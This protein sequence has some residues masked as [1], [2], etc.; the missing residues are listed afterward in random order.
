MSAAIATLLSCAAT[1][2]GWGQA[3]YP[4][5]Y[6]FSTLAGVASVGSADGAGTA[7]CFNQPHA[8]ALDAAGNLFVAD[9]GN[10]TIRMITPE[11][12]VSTLAGAAGEPG[13]ADGAGTRARFND[14][15]AIAVGPEGDIYVADTGNNTIRRISHSGVVSTLAGKAGLSGAVDGTGAVARFNAPMGIGVD[16]QGAIYV[17]DTR[18]DIVRKVL[19]SGVVTTLAG[20]AGVPGDA[21]GT[22]A[23]ARFDLPY[24]IAVDPDGNIYSNGRG[25]Q[26]DVR[27]T[28][29]WIRRITPEGVVTTVGRYTYTFPLWSEIHGMAF[30]GD[31]NRHQTFGDLLAVEMPNGNGGYEA[32]DADH[33]MNF[34]YRYLDGPVDAP[35][36]FHYPTG[37]CATHSGDVYLADGNNVIRKYTPNN[38]AV[39]HF[40]TG[41]VNTIAGLAIPSAETR[42][43]G[44][45]AAARFTSPG[46]LVLAPGGDLLVVDWADLINGTT[47]DTVVRRVSQ[48]GVVTTT[49]Q[50]PGSVQPE[51]RDSAGNIYTAD[52]IQH[53][54]RR[55]TPS[56]EASTFAGS[57]GEAGS[58][59]GIGSAA[60][61]RNPQ[62]VAVDSA[63]NVFVADTGNDTIRLI[64]P[65]GEVTTIGGFTGAVGSS[66]GVGREARFN[67]P[68]A[69]AVDAAGLVYVSSSTTI[70]VGRRGLAPAMV[71]QPASLTAQSGTKVQFSAAATGVP[72]PTCQWYRNGQPVPG[73]T[74]ASLEVVADNS[75]AGDYSAVFTNALGFVTSTT[76]TLT[77]AGTTPAGP[78]SAQGGG[79]GGAVDPGF[80]ALMGAAF[81]IRALSNRK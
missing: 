16:A 31:G 45:G 75:T 22:G 66:D 6:V 13:S 18:N 34:S 23:A 21:D 68:V 59:D 39:G 40:P 10:N 36:A 12:V 54:I 55:T 63:G 5:P 49:N 27:N 41:W 32:G 15:E 77:L 78:P 35:A 60:R 2:G 72:A 17:A 65:G 73:A 1:V 7:A 37:I 19:P 52:S 47:F 81:V 44:V 30:D 3:Q 24:L 4:T 71:T 29:G 64:T 61:F 80:L 20:L 42:K 67:R 33:N 79:G 51:A 62:S 76:A 74:N 50:D 58:A 38:R 14:P 43:D 46:A 11:G 57:A 26:I 69:I 9:T 8:V 56:G 28:R 53:V 70:R 48:G 25:P